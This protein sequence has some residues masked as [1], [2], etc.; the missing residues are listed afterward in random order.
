MLPIVTAALG[1][2]HVT[3][4]NAIDIV[5]VQVVTLHLLGL[6]A[7]WAAMPCAMPGWSSHAALCV[8]VLAL[9]TAKQEAE[10]TA[11]K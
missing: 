8:L 10:D 2:R 1:C 4:N 3:K 11:P 7:T 6:V 5:T 9:T